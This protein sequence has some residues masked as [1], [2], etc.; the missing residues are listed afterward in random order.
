MHRA[1]KISKRFIDSTIYYHNPIFVKIGSSLLRLWRKNVKR[2]TG[3]TF[4]HPLIKFILYRAQPPRNMNTYH[5][6]SKSHHA[7]FIY[8]EKTKHVAPEVP[9]VMDRLGSFS[10]GVVLSRKYYLNSIFIKFG[11]TLLGL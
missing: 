5:F 9:Q 2:C 3:G 10:I 11:S 4:G 7:T 1:R 6:L 8:M